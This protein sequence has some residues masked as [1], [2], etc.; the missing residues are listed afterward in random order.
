MIEGPWQVLYDADWHVSY[1]VPRWRE[2]RLSSK[3]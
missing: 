1:S 3:R 2:Q